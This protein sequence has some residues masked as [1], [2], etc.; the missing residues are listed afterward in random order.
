MGVILTGLGMLLWSVPL[1]DGRLGVQLLF[2]C[3]AWWAAT[4]MFVPWLLL[5]MGLSVIAAVPLFLGQPSTDVLQM[6]RM[7][8]LPFLASGAVSFGV[9]TT[10]QEAADRD[11]LTGLYN[12]DCLLQML[13]RRNRGRP[14]RCVLMFCDCNEFKSF[15]DMHGHFQGDSYLIQVATQLQEVND[16]LATVFRYGGDEFVVYAN[17]QALP[18]AGEWTRTVHQQLESIEVHGQRLRWSVGAV[19]FDRCIDAKEMI[20]A[21]DRAMYLAKNQRDGQV[22]VAE[23]SA[24]EST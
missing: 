6:V 21:A 15:N 10:V 19:I 22:Y 1:A 16:G 23:F 3:G 5:C 13:Q 17:T 8:Y 7:Y 20:E 24:L 11:R 9:R 18:S 4:R 2:M 12:R 14:Q